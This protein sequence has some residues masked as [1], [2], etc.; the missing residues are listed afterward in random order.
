[1]PSEMIIMVREMMA[2]SK[3]DGSL[4][5]VIGKTD[6]VALREYVD[7]MSAGQPTEEGVTITAATL[8]G[9]DVELSEPEKV[10]GDTIVVYYHGG[11]FVTG[12]AP[13]GRAYASALAGESGLR[14]YAVTYRLAPENP[15]PAGVNDCF[16]LYQALLAKY[17]GSRIAL[18][19][20]SAGGTL[21]LVV[22]LMAKDA[23]LPLP[24]AVAA[25]SPCTDFAEDLPSRTANRDT[26]PAV[27]S[28]VIELIRAL[29]CPG[30]ELSDPYVSP[31]RGDYVGF[32]PLM[33]VVDGGE[34]LLDDSLLLVEKAKQAGVA[35]ELQVAEG[36]FHGFPI[37]G[38]L[39]PESEQVLKDTAEFITKHSR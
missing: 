35:V 5:I 38:R 28:N 11:S 18:T 34:M 24:S 39:S 31:L 2:D 9:V 10:S 30:Q 12:N 29:Y 21:A 26:D 7:N 13:A 8:G 3:K 16:A 4:D 19:G 33:V 27:Q 1:M 20:E 25:F 36:C 32:P 22:T 23:G 14:V 6:F 15:Y 17:P 37:L